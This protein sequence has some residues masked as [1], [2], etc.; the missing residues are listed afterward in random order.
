MVFSLLFIVSYKTK[1]R[2]LRCG[3]EHSQNS[4]PLSAHS[5]TAINN[6]DVNNDEYA[7]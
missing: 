3:L 5:Q 7:V 1:T 2:S 4:Y 6:D